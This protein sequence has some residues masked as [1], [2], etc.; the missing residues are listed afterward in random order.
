MRAET[1]ERFT[2]AF[3]PW[4]FRREAFYPCYGLAEATLIVSGGEKGGPP[5]LRQ[6]DAGALEKGSAESPRETVR[7]L[8]GCGGSL[9]GQRIVVVEPESLRVCAPGEVGEIWVGGPSVASGY[10]QRQYESQ[11][12]FAAHTDLGDGPFL[13][14][15]DLGFLEGG[16]L[17]VTGRRKEVL[18][19]RGRNLY[20]HDLELTVE[21]SHPALRPGC[22][23][24]FSV[25]VEREERLVVVQEVDTRKVTTSLE[26]VAGAIR[27]RLAE[28]HEVMPYALVLIQPGSLPKTSSG[29]I[30]RYACRASFL[31]GELREV[32]AWRASAPVEPTAKTGLTATT[33][34]PEASIAAAMA[35]Y[36][37][38]TGAESNEEP[39]AALTGPDE[40]PRAAHAEHPAPGVGASVS[41]TA[42]AELEA[43]VLARVAARLGARVETLDASAPLT[44]FGLDSLAAVE[45]THALEKELGVALPAELLLGGASISE[46]AREIASRRTAAGV[47]AP[48][49]HAP[50]SSALPLSF[51][52]QRLW[53]LDRMEPGSAFYNV[54]VVSRLEGRLDAAALERSLQALVRR[55]EALRTT[56]AEERGEPVQRIQDA[57]SLTLAQ[58]ELQGLPEQA[59]EVEAL[60]LTRE[61]ARRPFDLARGPLV[62]ATLLRLGEQRHVLLLTLH[63]IIADGW[64]MRVLVR[65]LAELYEGFCT[66]RAPELD[67]LPLQYADYAAWQRQWLRGERLESL[68]GWWRQH[69]AGA[70]PVLELPIDRPR[71]KVQSYRGAH[72]LRRVARTP[73]ERV[74]AL[75]QAEGTTPFVA[76]LAGFQVLLHRYTGQDDVVVGVDTASRHRPETAGLIGLFVNQLPLRGDLSGAPS[77]RQLLARLH[78]LALEA[79]AHQELPFDELVRGLNPERSLAHAPVFQVKLVLQD[80][81]PAPLRLP[82]LSLESALGDTGATKLDLTLSA[83]DTGSGLELLCEYATDLFDEDTVGRMLEQLGTLL[84]EAASAPERRI[85]ELTL[86]S[87]LERHRALSEWSHTAPA[88]PDACAHHLFEEQVHRTPEAPAV[89]FGERTLTYRELDARANQL[90][91]HLRSLGVGPDVVVGVH[92][93]RSTELAVALLGVLKAGGAFLPLDTAYPAARLEL[94]LREAR[95]PVLV[96]R[97]ALADSLPSHGEMLVLVDADAAALER[98][99]RTAPAVGVT[100][101][102]LAYVIFTSGST[103]TPKGTLLQ[104]RGLGNTL[105]VA[106]EALGLRPG[107]RVLQLAAIGFDA[108]VWEIFPALC[109]GAELCFAPPESLLPGPPLQ[110]V[111]AEK[112]ITVITATPTVLA[113]LAPEA[114]PALEVVV[115][116]GEACTPELAARWKPGRRFLNGYGPTEATV[117]ATLETDVDPRRPSIG[118]AIAGA[119]VYVL[120][121]RMEPVPPG[122]PGE[123]YVGSPGLARGYLHRPALTAERFVPDPFATTP[124][125]RLY[126]TGDRVRSLADGRLEFLGRRDAQ[127]KV[128]GVRVELGEVEAAL[129]QCPG[130]RQAV[131]VLREDAGEPRLVAYAVT[132]E[133]MEAATLRRALK[134]RLPEVLVPSAFVMLDALPLTPGGKVDRQALPAPESARPA[135]ESAFVEARSELER[136]IADVWARALQV[137]RVGLHDHFFDDLGGSSLLVVKVSTQLRE[138][139][140]REVPVTHF[141]EHPTVHALAARLERESTSAP[142]PQRPEPRASEGGESQDIAI[143]GMAGRF[144]GAPDVRT[145]WRNLREGVESISRFTPV[146]LEPS[147]LFPDSLRSHPDF[148]P[149]GGVLEGAENFDAGFFEVSPREANWMD[150]QQRLFLQC[151]W[152]ALEDAGYDPERFRGLISLHAGAGTSGVHMMSLL[153]QAQRDPASLFEALGTTTGEN[154]ATKTAYKLKLAG[155]SLNV[156]TACSTGLVAVHL[157]CQSLRTRQSD[158]ALAGA[159][160]VSLPQR[161]GYLFQEG[162]ILSPDGHCRAFD[163]RARGTVPGSGLGVV[164]LKRLSDALRDGDHVYAVIKG[165]ALNNDAAAKVSYTAPSVQ[166]QREVISRALASASVDAASI[167]YVEAHGTGTPLGDPIEIAALTRAYR[168]H[169]DRTGYCAIGSVKTNIGHLD[170]AAGIAGLIKAALALH[171]GELPPSL[172]FDKPNPEIDFAKSPFFVN[173]ALRPWERGEGPRRAGVSSFG[174]GGTNAHVVLEEAPPQAKGQGSRRTRQLVTLSARS[175]SALDAMALELATYVEAHP[176]VDLA[177]LAFTRAMGRKAFELRRAV[178]ARDAAGLVRDLRKLAKP[179]EIK[180]LEAARAARV[181]F[182]FP[183]QGAQ[184][185]RMAQGL[186]AT[187]PLFQR[188]LDACLALLPGAGLTE[189]LRPVLFPEQGMEAQAEAKLAEPRFALPALLAV[190]Y[191]LARMWMGFGFK[192]AAL[193]GH[194]FGEYA[195]ACLAGVLSLE[196]ALRLAV[197]R[198]ELM[199]RLPPGGMLAV[200]LPA[201]EVMPLM[202]EELDLAAL[203]GHERC[204]VS[205]PREALEALERTLASSGAGVLRLP[206][207]HA[208]HSRAV[209]PLMPELERAVAGMTLKAPTLPY[210]SSLTGT[211]I[212]PEEATSP[213]YWARQMREPVRFATGLEALVQAGCGWFIE[214]GPDHNLTGLVRPRLR[215]ERQA[216]V[217]PSLRR[218]GTS[219]SDEQTLLE[220]LGALWCA[221]APVDWEGFFALEQRRRISLPGYAFEEKR[222]AVEMRALSTEAVAAP[223]SAASPTVT[224]SPAA[225]ALPAAATVATS[226]SHIEQKL[227]ELWRERLGITEIGPDDNFLALGGNSLMAAQLLTRLRDT[228]QVQVPLSDL[229]EAPTVSSLAARIEARL[230]VEAPARQAAPGTMV[231]IPRT[232]D[233][234]MSYVQARVWDLELQEPGSSIFNEP[235][236][237]RISGPLQVAAL[238]RGFNEVIRRHES[239]RIVFQQVEGRAVQRILPEVRISLPVVDLRSFAGDLEAEVMRRARLDPAEPFVLDQGPLVRVHL[240]RLAETEHVLLLTIHHIVADTLSLV[241]FIREAMALYTGYVHGISVPLPELPIQYIDF[242]AWQRKALVDGTLATQQ[243]YWRQRLARRPGPLPLPLDRPRVPGAR[244]RGERLSFALSRELSADL[245]AFGKRENLTAYMTLL[246]GLKALFARCS[247]QDDIVIGTSIGNRTRPELEPQIGYVAHALALR[248]NLEG[249]PG[250]RELALRVRDTTL[251]AFANPDVPYEQLLGELEPGDEVKY[252]RLFDAV[253]LLHAQGVSAPILDFP[254]LRLSYI[255]VTE[256]P[257][258]YGTALADM[259]VLMREDEHG[260]SGILEFAVDLFDASTIRR[261]LSQLEALLA[262]AMVSPEKPLSRL[263]LTRAVERAPAPR[264]E[265]TGAVA[266]TALLTAQAERTPDAVALRTGEQR[267]SWRDARAQALTLAAALRARGVGPGVPVA[268]CLEPSPERAVALWGVLA[269]GGAYA[270]VAPE[271]LN[272]LTALSE[273]GAAPLLITSASVS[274]PSGMAATRVIR[275]SLSGEAGVVSAPPAHGAEPKGLTLSLS[276]GLHAAA[277]LEPRAV[278]LPAVEADALACLVPHGEGN[279]RARVMLS[280]RNLVHRFAA[281]DSRV[282]ARAGETW[283]SAP[284]ASAD[285]ADLELLWALS[286]GLTVAFP[287]KTATHGVSSRAR[288]K[289]TRKPLDFSLFYF[290]NDAEASGREKYKLLIEGAKFADAHGFSAVWTP[291]RH[292]HAFGGPYPNPIATSSALAMVTERVAIR[293]GSVVLPL[294]DPIRVAEDWSV[295]DNLSNGR[296]GVSF[297]A[298]WNVNDFVFA[299][300]NFRQRPEAI[301]RGVEEVRALWRG[302]SVRRTNGQGSEVDISIRPRPVQAELPIWLTAAFNPE[303]FRMAGELGAGLL[304]NV[305]GLGQDFEELTR[306]IALYREA[307]RKAG[308]DRG[309][310]VLMLH[311]FVASTQDEVKRQAREPLIRYFRSS[312]ELFHGLV[313]SQGLGFDPSSL[314][315]RDMEVLLEQ[316]V[317]RYLDAGGLF[318]TP[319]TLAARIEQLRQADVDEVACLVD[320]GLPHEVAME[321]LRHLDVLRRNSQSVSEPATSTPLEF[322]V[323]EQTLV[324]QLRAAAPQHLRCTAALA[325]S[326][327]RMPDAATV[328]APVR[329]LVLDEADG[330]PVDLTTGLKAATSARVVAPVPVLPEGREVAPHASRFVLDAAG[331]HAPVGVVGELFL[332]G[333]AVPLGFWKAPELARTR[334]RSSPEDAAVRLFGTGTPARYRVDGTVEVLTPTARPRPPRAEPSPSL[335]APAPRPPAPPARPEPRAITGDVIPRAPRNRPLPLSFAQQR[336]WFLARL[337]PNNVAYNSPVALRMS[338]PLDVAAVEHGLKELVRRHEVLRTVYVHE[339]DEPS[340][341]ILPSLDMP[342]DRVDLRGI[343]AASLEE[344]LQERIR[345]RVLQ[346][347]DLAR[348]PLMRSVLFQLAEEEHVLLLILHHIITD[349]WS[350]AVLARELAISYTAFRARIPT[351]LPEMPLQY[352]DYAAWQRERLQGK[353][354]EELL[355]WWKRALHG[356]SGVLELPTDHPMPVRPTGRGSSV[357]V[358]MPRAVAEGLKSLAMRDGATLFMALVAGLQ[359]LLGRY[360]GQDDV[361]VGTPIAG[362]NRPELENLIGIFVNT[363][364][365]RGDLSGDPSFRTLLNRVKDMAVG[366]YAHQ[367]VPFEKLVEAMEVPRGL[368]RTPLFQVMVALQNVPPADAALPGMRIRAQPLTSLAAKFDLTFDITETPEGLVGTLEFTTDLYEAAS[369]ARLVTHLQRLLEAAVAQPERRLSELSLLTEEERRKLVIEWNDTRRDFSREATITGL[370]EARAA[371]T[372]DALAFKMGAESLTHGEL[373]RRANQLAHHLRSLGVGLETV[374]GVCLSRSLDQMV[375]VLAVLKAGGAFLPLE[376]SH[377]PERLSFLMSDARARVVLTATRHLDRL[378]KS[379]AH[380]VALDTEA[381]RISSQPA[382][383][384]VSLTH[385]ESLAYVLYTSGSTGVPKGVQGHHRGIVNRMEWSWRDYPF[386]PGEV[387]CI[388]APLGFI[389]SLWEMFG[390]LLAGVPSVLIPEDTVRNA[391]E[392]VRLL[393]DEGVTRLV[394]VPSLLQA[395]LEVEGGLQGRLSRLWW[396]MNSGEKLP[397]DLLR[398]FH[399]ALPD[400]TM[401]NIYGS[402]EVAAD[403]TWD[404]VR[405]GDITIGRPLANVRSYVLDPSLRLVPPGLGGEVYVAGEGLARGYMGRPDLTADRFLPDPFSTEPGA[406]MYRTGDRGRYR[407]DGRLEYLGRADFQVKVRGVR[408]EL[409]EVEAALA[410]HP[411]VNKSAATVRVDGPNGARL[412]AYA[413]P[414]PGHRLDAKELRTFLQRKLPETMM[415]SAVI[416][417]EKMPLTASGKV[418]RR[419]LPALEERHAE[420]HTHVEPRTDTERAVARIWSEVLRVPKVGATDSFFALGGHSLLATQVVAR[421]RNAMKVELPLQELFD[422]TTVE[423]I[424]QRID[425]LAPAASSAQGASVTL[426]RNETSGPRLV[427]R[428]RSAELS[429]AQQR[430]WFLDQYQPGS[431]LYNV[432]TAVR[433]EGVIDVRA[434]EQAFAELVRRHQALRTTFQAREAGPVQVIAPEWNSRLEVVS[435]GH[436]PEAAREAEALRLAREEA[437]KPFDLVKGP[438]L[439]ATLLSLSERS[440]LLLMTMHHIVSDGWSTGVLTREV[441]TL[442]VAFATGRP[443]PLPELPIQYADYAEWQR[444]WLQGE[445]LERQL[446]WWKQRL[447][448]IPP[449]LEL[450]TDMPRSADSDS[451]G[452]T[453]KVE[454]SSGLTRRLRDFCRAEGVTPFM[455]LLAAFQTVLSRYTGQDDICVGAPIAGRRQAETEGLIGFFVNTLVMRTR[456]DGDPTFRELLGR[457]KEM[458]LGAYAHQDV[459]FEKLVEVLQPP[460]QA[461]RTPFFQVALV[462]LNTPPIDVELPGLRFRPLDVDSGTAKFDFTLTMSETPEGLTGKLEYRSDLYAPAT[463]ER[464]MAHLTRLLDSALEHPEHHL[465]ELSLLSEEERRRVLVDF[466]TPAG[467]S[468]PAACVHELFDAQAARTPRAVAV[469]FEGFRLTYAELERRANQLATHLRSRGVRT[470]DRV[471]VCMER[472][473]ELAVAVLAILKAGAAYVPLDPQ[474]PA[475]RLAFMVEDSGATLVLTQSQVARVLPPAVSER[476]LRVD[477]EAGAIS[478]QPAQAPVRDVPPA[479]TCYVIYTSGSTGRPKGVA[480][481]HGA[482]SNL[483]AWQ[484]RQ[485]VK[486]DAVTLQFASLSFDVS[487][488]ELFSTWCAGG[489]LV[490]PTASVRQDMPALLELMA[491]T[492]V[493]RTFLPFVALQALADA[494]AD[495]APVPEKL[496]EVVTAGEQLQ[497]TPSVVAF[498]EKLPG[499]V[500]ENQYGP[501]ETHVVSAYRLQGAPA[502]WP[503]LP[504]IG[505]PLPDT[506]LYVLDERGQPCAIGVPGEL[507]IGGVQVAHGY[508]GRPELTAEKFVP[509]P[510]SREPG[511]RLYRTGDRASW[512][513]EGTLGF[514]GRLDG[515]VKVRGFRIELGEVE[516]ALRGAPGVRDAAATVREDSPGDKRLVGYVVS[517]PGATWDPDAVRESLS[518]RLPEYLV[519]SALVKLEALPL[520]PSGKLARRMLPA[521]DADSVRGGAPH[522]DPRTPLETTLANIVAA[523][524]KLPRVSVTDS[525]FNLGGHSLLATQVVSRIRGELGVEL[526]LRAL[527]E[528]PTVA[529][530]ARRIEGGSAVESAKKMPPPV[531]EKPPAPVIAVRTQE[532]ELS[533][534]QLRLW[535][536]DQYAPG[537]ALYN[538]PAALR[539]KGALDVGALERAFAELVR[540][541]Q[542]LRT[543]I[544][545]REGRPVQV[546]HS[547]MPCA[548]EVVDLRHLPEQGREAEAVRLAR[549]EAQRPFDLAKGPLLRTGLLRLADDEHVLLVTMHHIVSDGWSLSVLVREVGLL[550]EAFLSGQPSPLPELP[551]QYADYAVR[552]REW[553]QGEVLESQL[554][555]WKQRLEGA[556]PMLELPTDRPRTSD[557]VP[558]GAVINV[559]LPRE[560]TRALNNLCKREGATLFMGLLAGLQALLSRYTGQDDISVGAP[561]AGRGQADTEGLIGFFVNTLVLRTR[562][563]G[564][565]T[566]RELLARVKDVTLGA[567]AHQDVPF[568]KLVEVLQ[569][570]RQ[571]GQTPFFQVALGLLNTPPMEL[572]LR[573]LSLKPL[574]NVDSGTAKFDLTLTMIEGPQGLTGALEYR[575]DLFEASTAKRMMEHW[576]VLLENAAA[577]P[578]RR[579]SELAVQSTVERRRV[580]VDWNATAVEYPRDASLHAL[581]EA[582]VARS[583][584]AVALQS[585][586]QSLTYAQLERRANQV[587]HHL[588]GEGVRAGDCVALCM[589]RSLEAIIAVL[590]ILKAGAAYVPLDPTAPTER[591]GFMLE[592]TAAARVLTLKGSE[593]H[594]P[595]RDARVVFIDADRERIA[596]MPDTAPGVAVT[597]A[598]LAYVMYTSGSTG[599]PKGVCVPHRGVVRLVMGTNYAR[600]GPEEVFLQLAPLAFDASTFELWGSLLHGSRL[601]VAPAHSPTLEELGRLLDQHRVTTLWL[602]A[603]LY[604][605]MMTHQPEAVARVK[606]VLAGGDVLPPVRVR[607]H[608]SRGGRLVNGYGPTEGTTFTCCHVMTD[609]AEVGHSVSIGKPIANTRVYLLDAALRP[610]PVGVPGEL[611]I[612]GDGLAWGYLRRPELTAERF[613][614]DPFSPVA[615]ARLYRSGD[616]ARWLPDGRLQFLGRRDA[617]VKLR[618]FRVEPGEVETVLSH[619][620]A[621]REAAVVIRDDMPGGR[622]LVAYVT[623][624]PGQTPEPRDLR[625]FLRDRLPEYMVPSA[626]VVL[627]ALPVT[628]NGKLDRRA[629]P[630]PDVVDSGARGREHVAPRTPVEEQVAAL[631][632][633]VLRAPRVGIHDDFFERGG[634]SLLGTQLLSRLQHALGVEL[635][636]RALFEGPTVADLARRIEGARGGQGA[637]T[638]AVPALTRVSR[639]V[640]PLMSF[641]QERLWKLFK[642]NPTST[643]YNQPGAIRFAGALNLDAL[644]ATLQALMD[645]HESLRT[646]FTEVD[647]RPVQVVA[648][649]APFEVPLVDLRGHEDPEAEVFRLVGEEARRPFDLV[650]GPLV[651][652]VLFQLADDQYLLLFSK[653]HILSDGW[654][655]GVLAREVAHFYGAFASGKAPTLAPLKVQYPDFAAWQRGWLQG[656]E[657]EARLG[658]WR[659]ALAGAPTLLNL[660]TDKPRPATRTFNG[661]SLHMALGRARTDALNTLCQQERVT[662]FMALLSVFGTALC[663]RAN[664]EEVVVGSPIANRTMPELE[665]LIGLFVNGL[666][667]R[668]DLRGGPTF[669]QLLG[670]VRDVTLGAYAHQ[671]V[672]FEQVVDAI[673]VQRLPNRTPLF[674]VMFALQNAPSD[675]VQFP[676]LTLLPIPAADRGASIYEMS[677]SMSEAEDGFSGELEFNLDLFE[678]ATMERLRDAML[679]LLDRVLASPETPVGLGSPMPGAAH[680]TK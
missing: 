78:P 430:L 418:D 616:L 157:A 151:A 402:S 362:R 135:R 73:W 21:G 432:P 28:G 637:P 427:A 323:T 114:L 216:M 234:P 643:A 258:Q 535:L 508:A 267:L 421:V 201:E 597:S 293:A 243:A 46:L 174:I 439:R 389:D 381:G 545:A 474:Y 344:T 633:E 311:T 3:A 23:A 550:Y 254:G 159:V 283:L 553:L 620:P 265:T 349:G 189:D 398:R 502:S 120:D 658:Y 647:G 14:T 600:F 257:A 307:R 551:I 143:I 630:H 223:A 635:P 479:S 369:M 592:D 147:P 45:L 521:P 5:R 434:L 602:T 100:P 372:P 654:S 162:M 54:P 629:L 137:P 359:A 662:P 522:V 168:A 382:S 595:W 281:L 447:E 239:L 475:E 97:E 404:E 495:G 90:A 16:E 251:S 513:A 221:G 95:V 400:A 77:F 531:A 478:R 25:E 253:F 127:V 177:D 276:D 650:R 360:A 264:V 213:R 641:S 62:R 297:A 144:P 547:D 252:S 124:G 464:M 638:S 321:S 1:L 604:E 644:R 610:V 657:L 99:P 413:V 639:D 110:Q 462:L 452:A 669:R 17:Y 399:A 425:A 102:H 150:P 415:P 324:E 208:F 308:H 585:G 423:A 64:S 450:P 493:E 259:T 448:G 207:A 85:G 79:W 72:V 672:P 134:E 515:Q 299:R 571:A 624:R 578:Q 263:S 291:E 316:G 282:E 449:A 606:Q 140:G 511:A 20:P 4:G 383:N 84:A 115:S 214:A 146:E 136:R 350:G 519:P 348:G 188:E 466:N 142:E 537:S 11:S 302:G 411:S 428:S 347:F 212:R 357:P 56:F 388:K 217:V 352:A 566:F 196:D 158:L 270:L 569:P 87:E 248:T 645:R 440:H 651:R 527:F 554:A 271:E 572:A 528:A 517:Q 58:V 563:D 435:L 481:P 246:A 139:L 611:Y 130:V 280:H 42:Q 631:M 57:L 591:L 262:D 401:L 153:G 211:W 488:Q 193:L 55:H 540:R 235:L 564:N 390:P 468:R 458:A 391:P 273:D 66:G 108:S 375:A 298:G 300:D 476:L 13:R 594:L 266:V 173:T 483:L 296:A 628:R 514:L 437:R 419:A 250:F 526:P 544:R 91:W 499:C 677:L 118:R 379:E 454:L 482:L 122:V 346:P 363:L 39:Q 123:L 473:L 36:A 305:L 559:E 277:T 573:G 10:W 38:R 274:L 332:G 268:V 314:T 109:S 86:L 541:H 149:A 67:A 335:P 71:P 538:V 664:Q 403:A 59:R 678:P 364:V 593:Q 338:G 286:R 112:R 673:G 426:V 626:F 337:E 366:A 69:L 261:M 205:G 524:L 165:S 180:D 52:Q 186:Y 607:E 289:S 340:Q 210:V 101:A 661:T 622:A 230:G 625:A 679:A 209:E 269:S 536:V 224:P 206:T 599:Q 329:T 397:E 516:A 98:Q 129:A 385:P 89:S 370:F 453:L 61:E 603:A 443:S 472:S 579:L 584:D 567:Y 442:Y 154:V 19:L 555:W 125:E 218:S 104:H 306:K 121:E 582:Q 663:H 497:V 470:G 113:P 416:P 438:L 361:T 367:D 290:A 636:L 500:L 187:E 184:S 623:A 74:K 325:R 229:F 356:T 48:I 392:L 44:R 505:S 589:E 33:A 368:R 304:T 653:H 565:P 190:E 455:A 520:T 200:G 659:A 560:L 396:W 671:E 175:A 164:A 18:I 15:G 542:S 577:Y 549:E 556:P 494:V 116:A 29:K 49:P 414:H 60:R 412:V 226:R 26:E 326:L 40:K 665:A 8:V 586:D 155:E 37:E 203:N 596:A 220:S 504:S 552:Q 570:T 145:F 590:G 278:P 518:R 365:I 183:G 133:V 249:D 676:G 152:N 126:R 614:P 204:V 652:S 70:P 195:A 649:P 22:G 225:P 171:H 457:V 477:A 80:A 417:L 237:V 88:T 192:P 320:F 670:R 169:T 619:H 181:A 327:A 51:A 231:P 377:P 587:A 92:L 219:T 387:C 355:G 501:S 295:V 436:L 445:V 333:D 660:P 525:F 43:R 240:L 422:L 486:P 386:Q 530:L 351:P 581:F 376:P 7:T 336:L 424:A 668:V 407:D 617:Q 161:S 83:T 303:T 24:A 393:A 31:I 503:R 605:Q 395:M 469:E 575:S 420:P 666:A 342:L 459:P 341:R 534:A 82:G 334:L 199:S 12:V 484:L 167:G 81:T 498:F 244:R 107:S 131:V 35:E 256:L 562:L 292:F 322:E 191:A 170:T 313:A 441:A 222:F 539:M 354:L 490:M 148:V 63:H 242:A 546:I 233:L 76:L 345:E 588:R 406:R 374:V 198:G 94:M 353:T 576:R 394:L 408:I 172:H 456:L 227:V 557:A 510:F 378:P 105:L 467:E 185:V 465:S 287:T 343:P 463:A 96:T 609:A 532:A 232:G 178:I 608:L 409:G 182:L 583:P 236:A 507:F 30:Q 34:E 176:E 444:E 675:P 241:N 75:A 509:D 260:F 228:F 485:S 47:L 279:H 373:N 138:A 318:G 330:L 667:L 648:P 405:A 601:V 433:M 2:E 680:E 487:F 160:K 627:D 656:R 331:A 615:G 674:Q 558:P 561:I 312:V 640:P 202:T 163:A 238:E 309:H 284:E 580:L 27:Q 93:E 275:L 32:Y 460:R 111:L 294:H 612:A 247:G 621:L 315:P 319:E 543:T 310:V 568:E 166:G 429:F 328:L 634:H 6:V 255:D 523:V 480:L 529:A 117:C 646:T 574:A 371:R 410:Q 446:S 492:G 613:I 106:R 215:T 317:T 68:L 632:A 65:E 642:L 103:G 194:S 272:G 119:R 9:P 50:R 491:R 461:D 431:A 489:T 533:F 358:R 655:E 41:A 179:S 471:G 288:A 496:R 512:T 506:R 245:N 132:Q 285:P 618:G 53:F 156:Y 380:I 128:R 301:R 548:M 141:F 197:V 598:D 384:P 339:A 451:P